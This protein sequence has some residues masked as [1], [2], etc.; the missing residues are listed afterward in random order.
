M[1]SNFFQ[2]RS[3]KKA[4]DENIRKQIYDKNKRIR[5]YQPKWE[6]EFTWVKL[7]KIADLYKSHEKYR[8]F[9]KNFDL[10]VQKLMTL[11]KEALRML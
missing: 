8:L 5:A 6:K 11:N 10:N 1:A 7:S 2:P 4:K 3:A 9:L